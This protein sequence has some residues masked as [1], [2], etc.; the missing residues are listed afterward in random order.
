MELSVTGSVPPP[1]CGHTATMVEKRLLVFGGRGMLLCH[2]LTSLYL[3]VGIHH[4][5]LFYCG[6]IN[7]FLPSSLFISFVSELILSVFLFK[8]LIKS[9]MCKGK[10]LLPIRDAISP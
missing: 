10:H 7:L 1:R 2:A 5:F 9:F 4:P 8:Y 3:E 6:P